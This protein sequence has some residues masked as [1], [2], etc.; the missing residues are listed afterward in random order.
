MT[1]RPLKMHPLPK[2]TLENFEINE[3]RVCRFSSTSITSALVLI[4][5]KPRLLDIS[6]LAELKEI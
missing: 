6:M 5:P 3:F 1:G 2:L 4:I